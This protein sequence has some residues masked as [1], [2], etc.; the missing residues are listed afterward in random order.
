MG[1][2]GPAGRRRP[3]RLRLLAR[4]ELRN[5]PV[6]APPR[7]NLGGAQGDSPAGAADHRRHFFRSGPLR[8]PR[9]HGAVRGDRLRLRPD[10]AATDVGADPPLAA[11]G[12]QPDVLDHRRHRPGRPK[13]RRG[14]ADGQLDGDSQHWLCRGQ[15][16][17]LVERP[18][19]HRHRLRI[20]GPDQKISRRTRLHRA[21]DEPVPRGQTG[22]YGPFPGTGRSA[23][24]R[25]RAQ[26]GRL[27]A[28]DHLFGGNAGHRPAGKPALWRQRRRE[29]D[30]GLRFFDLRDPAAFPGDAEHRH[31]HQAHQSGA[32][33]LSARTLRPEWSQL[34]HAEVPLDAG[35]CREGDRSGDDRQGRQSPD[36]DRDVSAGDQPRR[37]TAVFQRAVRRYVGGRSATRT[38]RVYQ[39]VSEN[40]PELHGPS[41]R[42][43]GHHRLGPGQWLA[44]QHVTSQADSV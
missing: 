37:A 13:N 41:C 18:R 44:G 43:V 38:A 11:P 15:S 6:A 24:D 40:D 9:R 21:A 2:S 27:D 12:L 25:R 32:D 4:Q 14:P 20:A 39:P 31:R 23:T 10:H 29:A 26:P 34:Q 35:R 33:F 36:A 16:H 3:G 28:D 22:V 42:E 1:L 19:H 17:P 5:Q 30:H 8:L 7:G